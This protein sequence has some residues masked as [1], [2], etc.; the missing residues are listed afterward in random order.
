MHWV[1]R[2]RPPHLATRVLTSGRVWLRHLGAAG[3]V[4]SLARTVLSY[5]SA[6]DGHG[7]RCGGWRAQT[8]VSIILPLVSLGDCNFVFTLTSHLASDEE[9]LS[10]DSL[11]CGHSRGLTGQRYA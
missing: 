8:S 5:G 3:T 1:G 11:R 2:L 7:T 9:K 6:N 10:Y 4:V